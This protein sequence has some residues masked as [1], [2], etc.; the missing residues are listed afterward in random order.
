MK[1]KLLGVIDATTFHDDLEELLMH[2]S[3]AALPFGGR[4]RMIDFV[5]SNMVNSGIRSVAI[6]PKLQCRSLMDHL[7]SGKNWDL[8]RK[9]DGL[10]FFPSPIN[11]RTPNRVG[12]FDHFAANL[13]YFYRSTQEYSIIA[14]CYTVFNFNF[15]PLL[16]W[17]MHSGCDITEIRHQDGSSMEMYLI[18]TSLLIKLIETRN[19]TGYTCMKDVVSNIHHDY[20]ICHY[21]YSGYATMIDSI[22]S[23]FST[24][25]ELLKPDIW[26]QVFLK[27]QPILTKVK[28]EPPTKY[29]KGSSVKHAMIA[30]GCIINGMVENS[31]IARGVTIGKGAVIKNSIIMQKCQIEEDCILD[32]VILDKDVKVEAG[33][34]LKGTPHSPFVIRKGTKQGALMNS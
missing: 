12:S 14:N 17:H 1:R 33:T 8:N 10:F 28:D 20:S 3:L 26:R 7:G 16:E 21:N 31:I 32:S 9:R 29:I 18:K 2:R 22:Q 24:S 34:H 13:D 15:R 5:L 25:M 11:D 4:Y 30:N 27:E 6:F 19:E 23:Y